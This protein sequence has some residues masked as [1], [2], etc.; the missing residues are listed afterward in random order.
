MKKSIMENEENRGFFNMIFLEND[1]IEQLFVTCG[2]D[3]CVISIEAPNP[4]KLKKKGV[5]ILKLTQ[6]QITTANIVKD[7][8]FMELPR[9]VLEHC[10]MVYHDIISPITQNTLNQQGWTELVSKDLMEKFNSYIAQIYVMIG[11]GK[12]RT[13]LPLPTHKMNQNDTTPDKDKA[14]V[15]ETSIMTWMK[16]IKNVLKLEPEMALKQKQDPGPLTELDFWENKMNNLN[17]IYEQL[18]SPEVQSILRF[19]E[20][21]KSTYTKPF[22]KIQ[23][24]VRQARIEANDNFR[25]LKSLK[26]EFIYISEGGKD[27]IDIQHYFEPIMHKILM[28]WKKS[29]FYNTPPRLVVLIREICNAIIGKARDFI[30]GSAIFMLIQAEE[31][32]EACEKLETTVAICSKFKVAYFEY[33]NKANQE[34]KLTTNALFVR[35]DSFLERCL[36][37]KH[38]TKTILEFNKLSKIELGGTKGKTLTETVQLIYNEFQE[39]VDAFQAVKYDIMDIDVKEFDDDFYEFRSKIKE[40]ERRLASVIT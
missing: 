34:W 17:S 28:I 14:H 23:N 10:Y 5:V 24:Q 37:I 8:A 21:N 2:A 27:F 6:E 32:A 29:K 25:Y 11:L 40:L 4:N 13:L 9:N 33:K 12:G 22:D 35:L 3:Q 20:D 7:L 18:Q 38:L 19:L 31:T 39:A 16:Q 1:C 36:D 15:F 26:Q 30:S